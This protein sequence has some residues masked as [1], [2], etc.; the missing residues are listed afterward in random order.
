MRPPLWLWLLLV[1]GAAAGSSPM[2]Q[3]LTLEDALLRSSDG[4]T[5]VSA[6]GWALQGAPSRTVPANNSQDCAAACLASPG[7]GWANFCQDEVRRRLAQAPCWSA[8]WGG[9]SRAS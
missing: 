5:V 6:P 3:P 1:V 8:S 9:L 7:C 4:S 2:T